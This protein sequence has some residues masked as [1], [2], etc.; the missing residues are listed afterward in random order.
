M[1]PTD[2]SSSVAHV[3]FKQPQVNRWGEACQSRWRVVPTC[4][5]ITNCAQNLSSP[6][7]IL[8]LNNSWQRQFS[9]WCQPIAEL[10]FVCWSFQIKT[11]FKHRSSNIK[12]YKRGF[13]GLTGKDQA[14]AGGLVPGAQIKLWSASWWDKKQPSVSGGMT[15]NRIWGLGKGGRD[16]DEWLT[17]SSWSP[18]MTDL[19]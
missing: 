16:K 8:F 10:L 13:G 1:P 6:S 2:N 18:E 4:F 12:R 7:H 14:K 11:S 17:R 5:L 15:V 19:F 3:T 9:Q